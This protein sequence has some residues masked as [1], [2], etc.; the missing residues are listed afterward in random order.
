[1]SDTGRPANAPDGDREMSLIEHLTELRSRLLRAIAALLAAF[2]ALSYYANPLYQF[3][4][5]PLQ[6]YLPAGSTMIATEVGSP[7]VAPFKLAFVA[8]ALLAMPY[9][10]YQVWAFVAPGMY[11]HEKRFALSLLV[12]SIVLF[13]S[14]VAFAYFVVCPLVFAFI[15]ST[16]PV[17]VTVMTDINHYLDF[18]LA[19]FF[20]FGAAFEVPVA[21]VLMV[22]AGLTTPEALVEKRPYIIVGCFVVGAVLTPPDVVS[23]VMLALPMWL[24]FEIGIFASRALTREHSN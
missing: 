3:V 6:R 18:V 22:W 23:Q 9:I 21:T 13:Y 8:G 1:M 5:E 24:L 17:G 7:F 16:T 11:R 2:L 19:M 10:L 14:G 20:A 15:T 4:A 12:S